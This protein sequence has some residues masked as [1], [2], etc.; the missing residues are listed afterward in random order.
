MRSKFLFLILI[1]GSLIISGCVREYN[2]VEITSI[3]V[4]SSPQDD[5]TKLIVTP[6]IQNNQNTDTGVLTIKVKIRDPTSNIIVAEKDSD[7]GYIKSKSG[8]SNSV[9]LAVANPGEYGVE[10]QLLESGGKIV[11]QGYSS[12]TIKSKPESG[13]PAEIK[14][15]DMNLVITKIYNDAQNAIVDVSPG[16]YN[17]GGDSK[18][19]T[20][21][22]TARVDP[23]TAY[24][25]TNEIGILKG[26]SSIRSK[27]TL[28]VPRNKEYAFTVSVIE[29]GQKVSGG[30]VAGKI[31]LNDIK[32]N[33]PMTYS[34]AEEE[35]PPVKPTP[36]FEMA[37]ALACIV[38]VCMYRR[39]RKR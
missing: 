29:N 32:F 5:G 35:K 30:A 2:N 23:Y 10:V 22:V 33:T 24:T 14:L 20:I 28:D 26:G 36:G 12:V 11:A 1:F 18:P 34:L 21:E 9:T 25:K 16:I 19:L 13:A 38:V 17:Q 7:I 8:A 6:Y 3:D 37:L 27:V 31:K 39:F 15:T 4:M